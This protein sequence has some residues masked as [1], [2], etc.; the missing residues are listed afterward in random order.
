MSLKVDF[1]KGI[2]KELVVMGDLAE[3]VADITTVIYALY[4]KLKQGNIEAAEVFRQDFENV[5]RSGLIFENDT[6]TALKEVVKKDVKTAMKHYKNN[7]TEMVR[8]FFR[9]L[10]KTRESG[11]ELDDDLVQSFLKELMKDEDESNNAN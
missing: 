9:G 8:D 4:S 11:V 5:V 10:K 1:E 7:R 6:K 3:I 2:M